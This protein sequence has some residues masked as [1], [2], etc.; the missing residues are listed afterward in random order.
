MIRQIS[1]IAIGAIGLVLFVGTSVA[2]AA[3][4]FL[5]GQGQQGAG[6]SQ[7]I[8]QANFCQEA[9][10]ANQAMNTANPQGG[11]TSQSISQVNACKEAVCTNTASNTVK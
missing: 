6:T 7:S 8:K 1:F 3:F 2:P 9:Y 10:C 5:G 11:S 4:A